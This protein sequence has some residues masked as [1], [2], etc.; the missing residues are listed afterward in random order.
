MKIYKIE[1]WDGKKLISS[2]EEQSNMG[3]KEWKYRR[4]M[5]KCG[6]F[7]GEL[8]RTYVDGVEQFGNW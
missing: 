7:R 1:K 6:G 2:F 4:A 8:M 3:F 5:K